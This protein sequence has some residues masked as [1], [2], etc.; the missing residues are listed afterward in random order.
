MKFHKGRA[1][2]AVFDSKLPTI[3]KLIMLCYIKHANDDGIA[4]PGGERLAR[5]TSTSLA[6]VKRHRAALLKA[7]VLIRT[8]GG[9]GSVYKV[10][11]NIN[12]LDA[13]ITVT[14]VSQSDR[15]QSD[16]TTGIRVTPP[17]V[18]EGDPNI[19]KEEDTENIHKLPSA[20]LQEEQ[21]KSEEI[22]VEQ[23]KLAWEALMEI[24]KGSE[25]SSHRL[26]L[27]PWRI[28]MIRQRMKSYSHD[29]ITYAWRWWNESVHEQA[30]YLRTNRGPAGIDTFLRRSNHDKYQAFAMMWKPV[31]TEPGPGASIEEMRTWLNYKNRMSI[32]GK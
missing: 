22:S 11:I 17:L 21:E 26:K 19:H 4:W 24:S 10:I 30:V 25:V 13:G 9:R 1:L 20:D 18:S 12:N 3:Q 7:G 8:E 5:M 28:S 23:V 14:P 29:E 6:S 31:I 27:T 16:T 15:Y 2:D 32:A